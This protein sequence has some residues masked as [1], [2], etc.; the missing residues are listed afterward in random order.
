[1]TEPTLSDST[2]RFTDR[3]AD[4]V[5]YRPTY[6]ARLIDWLRD[7]FGIN[8]GWLV[9][10]VGA[11]TGISS[12]LFLDA[13]HRV[14]AV[15][16]NSAM[17]EAAAQRLGSRQEFRTVG[18]RAEDTGLP[19]RSV[20]LICAAQSFHWFDQ[21]AIR[22]EFARI[23]R[24]GG[25]VAVFW[26]SRRLTG[27]PFLEQYEQLLLDYGTDYR[28]VADRYPNDQQMKDWF[29]DGYWGRTCFENCQSLDYESLRGRLL[30]SSYVPQPG[31]ERYQPMLQALQRLFEA[32]AEQGR[33]EMF[34]DTR[35]FIGSVD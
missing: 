25:L 32:C 14:I 23:L 20:D 22:Y 6:P 5:R 16:P 15:E 24:S 26:N 3:V 27:S 12:E 11:G 30:S 28:Q 18:G 10:D 1:M 21:Q 4:Y 33:V 31:H 34:Y 2:L 8:P 35:V 29:R 7:S 17:R 9:A 19:D 13:G